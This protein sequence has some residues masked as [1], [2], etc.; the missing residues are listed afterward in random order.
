MR[1]SIESRVPFLDRPLN[2]FL[3]SLPEDWLV[4]SDGTTKRILR[5]AVRGWIPEEVIN[6]RDKIG[7]ETPEAEWQA[8]LAMRPTNHDHPIGFLRAGRD[9]T[10]TGGLS[11]REIR[12]GRRSHWRLINLRRWVELLSIDAS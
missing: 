3:L 9:D 4:G 7:F 12:W 5:D 6:R 1:F 8:R 2:E 10:L 11:E